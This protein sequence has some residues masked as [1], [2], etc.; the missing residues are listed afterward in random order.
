[1]KSTEHWLVHDHTK[2]EFLLGELVEAAETQNWQI[3]K[4]GIKEL[5]RQLKFHMAREEDILFPAFDAKTG[6]PHIPTV[7]L[8]K[9]HRNIIRIFTEL[10]SVI[11]YENLIKLRE[12]LPEL[13]TAMLAHHEQEE[14]VFLP[15]ASRIL[16]E[17]R[18][19]LSQQ[20]E[21]YTL[22]AKLDY[23]TV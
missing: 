15:M 21:D 20:L 7:M 3:M 6:P 23:W 17:D 18:E 16:C 13:Q 10:Y 8:R 9:E 4:R 5:I 1:M 11:R 22:P 12:L 14:R 2:I 19:A